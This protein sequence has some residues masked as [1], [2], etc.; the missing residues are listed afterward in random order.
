V[1][2]G[3]SSAFRANQR[4]PLKPSAIFKKANGFSAS[5]KKNGPID[6][7]LL[8]EESKIVATGVSSAMIENAQNKH[9]EGTISS[10]LQEFSYF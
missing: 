2:R 7:E 10:F 5:P 8:S 1:E 4:P 6:D 9:T 3:A